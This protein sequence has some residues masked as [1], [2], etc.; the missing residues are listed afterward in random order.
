MMHMTQPNFKA[1]AAFNSTPG[2]SPTRPPETLRNFNQTYTTMH[3]SI[4]STPVPKGPVNPKIEPL[5]Q[6]YDARQPK[7]IYQ[8]AKGEVLDQ[9]YAPNP[10]THKQIEKL[11]ESNLLK[12]PAE[13]IF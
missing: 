1:A 3:G 4:Y 9:S 11:I 6:M 13:S 2:H 8:P 10:E 12:T 7:A 5:F